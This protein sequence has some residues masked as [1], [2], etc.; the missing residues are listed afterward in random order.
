MLYGAENLYKRLQPILFWERAR[1][2]MHM[3]FEGPENIFHIKRVR[4]LQSYSPCFVSTEAI[5]MKTPSII[6]TGFGK[7][8]N[9]RSE[10]AICP[11]LDGI[12]EIKPQ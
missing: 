12:W 3:K 7:P 4:N 1:I 2:R 8:D 5:Q 11:R 10:Q 6:S 9:R